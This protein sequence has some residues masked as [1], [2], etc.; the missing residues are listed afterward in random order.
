MAEWNDMAMDV[1]KNW[2][3]PL[4]SSCVILCVI[5]YFMGNVKIT[6]GIQRNVSSLYMTDG[7]E[8]TKQQYIYW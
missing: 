4:L 7:D 6:E 8:D 2:V 3:Y 1:R 5:E